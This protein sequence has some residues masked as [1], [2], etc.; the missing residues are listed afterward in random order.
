MNSFVDEKSCLKA[1]IMDECLKNEIK[2]IFEQRNLL[3]AEN[4]FGIGD[5][6]PNLRSLCSDTVNLARKFYRF[7]WK[8]SNLYSNLRIFNRGRGSC[9]NYHFMFW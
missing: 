3:V 4:H 9:A 7:I 1:L 5:S 6:A 8:S 2:P